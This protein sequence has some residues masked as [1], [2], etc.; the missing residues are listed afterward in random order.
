M[1]TCWD[2]GLTV[3]RAELTAIITAP[4]RRRMGQGWLAVGAACAGYGAVIAWNPAGAAIGLLI[5]LTAGLV[6][7][8]LVLGVGESVAAGRADHCW[9]ITTSRGHAVALGIDST[10]GTVIE[11]VASWPLGSGAG[12]ALVAQICQEADT[13]G[14][15]L[16]LTA[17]TNRLN[18][19]YRRFGF[20]PSSG[21]RLTRPPVGGPR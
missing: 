6:L 15:T 7:F 19:Y 17:A 20:Q 11:S 4:H 13:H 9:S 2:H 18:A 12:T 10:R 1:T 21:R 5:G 8:A 14:R 16:L 3:T